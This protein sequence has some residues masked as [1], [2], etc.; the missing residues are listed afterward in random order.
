MPL[1]VFKI[2]LL[3]GGINNEADP[4]YIKD[5]E[6]TAL[7]NF[8]PNIRGRLRLSG[9]MT[10]KSLSYNDSDTSLALATTSDYHTSGYGLYYF[11]ADYT[12]LSAENT[13]LTNGN[14][15]EVSSGV[16]YYVFQDNKYVKIYDT[17]NN[18]F[19]TTRINGATGARAAVAGSDISTSPFVLPVYYY[20]NNALRISAAHTA[21]VGGS[22]FHRR[23]LGF[24]N[25]TL[26]DGD[27]STYTAFRNHKRWYQDTAKILPPSA[28]S[29]TQDVGSEKPGKATFG[30]S[31]VSGGTPVTFTAT[32]KEGIHIQIGY[33][34]AVSGTWAAKTYK[35]YV[36]FIYDDTQESN[37]YYIGQRASQAN[38]GLTVSVVC[39][40]S[41]DNDNA[42]ATSNGFLADSGGIAGLHINPRVTG[43]RLY[44]SD[45]SDGHGVLYHMLDYDFVKG[46]RKV[47]ET[48]YTAWEPVTESDHE[49]YICPDSSENN[50][51]GNGDTEAFEF[52]DPP[53]IS[54]YEEINGYGP[55]EEINPEFNCAAI[56][57]KTTFIANIKIRDE[58]FNDRIMFSNPNQYDTFPESYV[59]TIG[60]DDGDKIIQLIADGDKL[61]VFKEKSVAVLNV[62]KVGAEYIEQS[63]NYIG[64]KNPCQAVNTNYGVCWVNS[65]GCFI[66]QDNQVI[67]LIDNKILKQGQLKTYQKNMLW[68]LSDKDFK[69]IP[70]IG[71]YPKQDQLILAY[72]IAEEAPS[73]PQDCWI[74]NFKSGAWSFHATAMDTHKVRSNFINNNL[75]ELLQSGGYHNGTSATNDKLTLSYWN[76]L[77]TSKDECVY[78]TKDL[79]FGSPGIKKKIY[80][81]GITYS[82]SKPSTGIKPFFAIDG[83]DEIAQT[84]VSSQGELNSS[85]IIEAETGSISAEILKFYENGVYKILDSSNNYYF[86]QGSQCNEGGVVGDKAYIQYETDVTGSNWTIASGA[87]FLSIAGNQFVFTG[88]GD[89]VATHTFSTTSAITSHAPHVLQFNIASIA[90]NMTIQII[91]LN[92]EDGGETTLATPS[93]YTGTGVK[94]ISF[95]P[96]T[97]HTTY[98]IKFL[99]SGSSGITTINNINLQSAFLVA[100]SYNSSTYFANNSG[101]S[102]VTRSGG[103][104]TSNQTNTSGNHY[105]TVSN[106]VKHQ[107]KLQVGNTIGLGIKVRLIDV[108]TSSTALPN[109]K[110]ISAYDSNSGGTYPQ[111][112][113]LEGDGIDGAS[114][115]FATLNYDSPNTATINTVSA[116]NTN[117]RY[118]IV[119]TNDR[120]SG[121]IDGY[122]IDVFVVGFLSMREIG[123]YTTGFLNFASPITCKSFQF[124]LKNSGTA[125]ASFTIRDIEIFYRVLR[126]KLTSD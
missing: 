44:F 69:N 117:N 2:P 37:T 124:M 97:S 90:T 93:Q 17:V 104:I 95:T 12:M 54:T 105:I 50:I 51:G 19:L 100:N 110:D 55:S 35:F 52:L 14:P 9:N 79:N 15:V 107:I 16:D 65:S 83:D 47:A 53:K 10:V 112:V 26:F 71:Y 116:L 45:P 119:I 42:Q 126:P 70:S 34:H 91:G 76:H 99:N 102:T 22:T 6:A 5:E 23:Y 88:S 103:F 49:T 56:I 73:R 109:L 87:S 63:F 58:V 59:I 113:P 60:A 72:N 31:D 41:N 64:I 66:I 77:S 121:T 57:G 115:D 28:S 74:Y 40:Y 68:N 61:V 7:N 82:T 27:G 38:K 1:K 78:V 86:I 89:A 120:P 106:N 96:T 62:S 3:T 11:R 46:C 33:D 13:Y 92:I 18:V 80:K 81:V 39:A 67:N 4:A 118:Y 125:D 111:S 20:A 98:K 114:A 85:G 75:G 101:T 29:Y 94:T 84:F 32:G 25:R 30:T 8:I 123:S 24:I 21:G 43:G 36:S 48:V 122:P 108:G